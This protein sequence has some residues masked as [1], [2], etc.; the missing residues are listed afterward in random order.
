MREYPTAPLVGIGIIVLRGVE[1]AEVLLARRGKAPALGAWSVPGGGQELGETVEAAARRELRE[2]TGLEVG[3][4][5]LVAHVDAI[6][7]DAEG[8]VQYHFT[9]LDFVADYVAGTAVAGD[10]V[11]AVAWVAVTELDDYGVTPEL[12]L[13]IAQ[14]RALDR[15]SG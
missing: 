5:T 12:R 11:S 9:I 14:A 10:D 6:N 3:R 7:R 1:R 2:E 13:M 4:L 15:N 8:R